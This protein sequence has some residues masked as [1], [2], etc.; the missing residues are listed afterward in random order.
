MAIVCGWPRH[1]GPAERHSSPTRSG[2]LGP[3]VGVLGRFDARVYRV[4]IRDAGGTRLFALFIAR[5]CRCVKRRI[6]PH[7]RVDRLPLLVATISGGAGRAD[8]QWVGGGHRHRCL[9]SGVIIGGAI[10]AVDRSFGG[11]GIGGALS[12]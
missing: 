1:D 3:V 12:C 4:W 11:R 10:S 8:D 5:R 2:D 6:G 7:P 9:V